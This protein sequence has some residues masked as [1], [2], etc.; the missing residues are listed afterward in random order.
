MYRSLLDPDALSEI[1]SAIGM[2]RALIAGDLRSGVLGGTQYWVDVVAVTPDGAPV[3]I[4]EEF[5][6][7]GMPDPEDGKYDYHAIAQSKRQRTVRTGKSCRQANEDGEDVLDGEVPYAGNVIKD[8]GDGYKLVVSVSGL[9]DLYDERVAD[10][11]A[12]G[13]VL[14]V[15][16][17]HAT[18]VTLAAH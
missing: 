10:H 14:N 3:F 9:S 5:I 13:I 17:M 15:G 2:T 4:H 1:R 16:G 18:K 6:D 11:T 8:I 7:S 12:S